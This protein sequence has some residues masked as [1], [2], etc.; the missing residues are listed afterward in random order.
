MGL[1]SYNGWPGAARK[2]R[3][4]EFYRLLRAK[5]LPSP[6]LCFLC[7]NR[8]ILDGWN[9]YHAEEYGSTWEDYVG[10]AKPL[11]PYC[12]GM[13]H[14]RF[15]FP[16]RFLRMKQRIADGSL[17][18]KVPTYKNLGEV[19]SLAKKL[20]DLPSIDNTSSGNQWLDSLQLTAYSGPPKIVTVLEGGTEFP[21]PRVYGKYSVDWKKLSGVLL[22]PTGEVI[23]VF[24]E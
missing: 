8:H 2:V 14:L 17:R 15:K 22:R 21:D 13:I 5:K 4:D 12:H 23:E 19:F 10:G 18:G 24:W 1:R 16:N 9:T 20:S 6:D 7:G 11:C 3:G